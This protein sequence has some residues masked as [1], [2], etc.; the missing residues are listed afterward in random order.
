MEVTAK[1][2]DGKEL[3]RTERHYHTQATTCRDE[4]MAY[5]AQNKTSYVRNTALQPFEFTDETYEFELPFDTKDGVNTPTL[6]TV[7]VTVELNYEIQNADNKIQIH[8]VTK[9]VTLDR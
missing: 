3:Y 5:G 8:K 9:Q 2:K 4:K 7:D 1:S 6:R